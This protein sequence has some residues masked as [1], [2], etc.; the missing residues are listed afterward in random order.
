L[1]D[2]GNTKEIAGLIHQSNSLVVI[3]NKFSV[4]IQR[5]TAAHELT[6]ALFHNNTTLHRDMPVHYAQRNI[7]KPQ[8]EK[9]ADKG[10]TFILMPRK[11]VI[12]EFIARFKEPFEINENSTFNLTLGTISDLRREVKTSY[13]LAI[14]LAVA[15]SYSHNYFESLSTYFHVS[16]QAMAYRLQELGLIRF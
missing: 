8:A 13:D 16:P 2:S 11:F 1:D 5:F 7:V 6:H 3:S 15:K 9:V 12:D 14:K 10:A 4:P